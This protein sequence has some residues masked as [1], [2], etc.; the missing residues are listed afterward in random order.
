I[1][2]DIVY[3]ALFGPV[4]YLYTRMVI[5]G[6]FRLRVQHLAHL[7]ILL[8]GMFAV[9]NFVGSTAGSGSFVKYF[10]ESTGF[11]TIALMVWEFG[12]AVYL[13]VCIFILFKHQRRIKHYFSNSSLVSLKWL[14]FLILGFAVYIYGAFFLWFLE[15]IF[16]VSIPF[17]PISIIVPVLNVYTLGIGIFG[18]RQ[19]TV[20]DF[21]HQPSS[22]L[23][24]PDQFI[25]D[26]I[27]RKYQ[28]SGLSDYEARELKHKLDVLMRSEKPYF[29]CEFS[30]NT[31]ADKLDTSIHKISQVINVV[32][33]KNFFEYVNDFRIE[34]TKKL[35]CSPEFDHLKIISLAYDCGFN[36]KSAFY[37][38]FKKHTTLT[39]SEYKKRMS[40]ENSEVSAN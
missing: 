13:L 17:R 38:A 1:L 15:S 25:S 40:T 8:A 12:A 36:S 11:T 16:D 21:N 39:P 6:N 19:K 34:E 22:P 23:K 18:Y 10:S 20:F 7:F 35:L 31:L 14:T 33:R 24:K 37:N 27:V 26:G 2:F 9:V 29:D 4:L 3:W 30:I 28:H 32:Y 5:D